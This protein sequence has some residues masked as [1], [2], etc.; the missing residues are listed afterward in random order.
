MSGGLGTGKTT[1]IQGLAAGL[2]V[3]EQINS[4]TFALEKRYRTNSGQEF[5][6][7]DLYRLNIR[8]AKEVFVNT[9]ENPVSVCAVE[10]PERTTEE[11]SGFIKVT[12]TDLRDLPE[13]KKA[14]LPVFI[15]KKIL[16]F[17]E[18]RLIQI[19]FN[20]VPIPS[21]RQIKK[22][23][24][25]VM[26]PPHIIEHC[27]VVAE[28]SLKFAKYLNEKHKIV[29]TRLLEAGSK[30]HDL[31]RFIDF[32]DGHPKLGQEPSQKQLK[33]WEQWSDK[34]SDFGHEHACASFL[35]EQGYPELAKVISVHGIK[36]NDGENRD[37]IEQ[38]LLYYTDKRVALNKVVT[39]EERF[40]DFIKRYGK[41][42]QTE[43]NKRWYEEA[44]KM[45]K[46]LFPGGVPF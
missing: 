46:E 27:E 18:G 45:E 41:G 17:N 16:L 5:R 29:R 32:H 10:W 26:L 19:K 20:D 36:L 4:P 6:H 23:R 24:K 7:L 15:R 33:L 3:E 43:K 22:W 39:L 42:K 8:Q 12:L 37:T 28:L 25:D 40:E 13:K 30:L 14:D 38:K 11:E 34:Y 9:M 1:F 21:S 2:G 44:K 31:L 35:E